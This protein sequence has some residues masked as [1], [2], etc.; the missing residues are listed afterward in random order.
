MSLIS[1][2]SLQGGKFFFNLFQFSVSQSV[3]FFR[4][5]NSFSC[6]DFLSFVVDED[7]VF[8]FGTNGEIFVKVDVIGQSDSDELFGVVSDHLLIVGSDVGG[9]SMN[10]GV[11]DGASGTHWNEF[12]VRH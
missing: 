4:F 10:T 11:F 5:S 8:V 6:G 9:R 3:L 1:V 2:F 7:W 12:R